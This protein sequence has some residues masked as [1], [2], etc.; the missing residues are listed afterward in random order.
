MA[1][2]YAGFA[3]LTLRA[4]RG[5]ARPAA[6][7][8]PSDARAS[9]IQSLLSGALAAGRG[10]RRGR[11]RRTA[12]G[13]ILRAAAGDGGGVWCWAPPAAVYGDRARLLRA[14]ARCG[15]PGARRESVGAARAARWARCSN[16]APR[17]AGCWP[18]RRWPARRSRWPRSA[19]WSGPDPAWAVIS[20]GDCRRGRQVQ[21]RLHRVLLRDRAR[22]QHL[23]GEHLRGRLVEVHRLPGLRAVPRPGLPLLPRLQP[24]PRPR[25]PG[26]LP[27]RARRLRPSAGSTATT[28]A[29]ASATP[30]SQGRPRWSAGW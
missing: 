30:R 16:G 13:W 3:V 23:P 11:R 1:A 26:R 12:L 19:T 27:V 5:A 14:A 22:A 4:G 15:G 21:R 20:P 25:L 28:F 7:S 17:A 18:A 24:D 9:P 2:L 29:T 10:C 6:A 8:A